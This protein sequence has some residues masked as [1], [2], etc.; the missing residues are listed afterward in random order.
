[1]ATDFD[2]GFDD[3]YDEEERPV[4]GAG[5]TP[6]E[7]LPPPPEIGGMGSY[8]DIH[9]VSASTIG[10]RTVS[11]RL[12]T[13]AAGHPTVTQL[14]V[15]KI[16]NGRP[17]GL[18]AIDAEASEDDLVRMFV[19]SMPKA[20]EG[21][22]VFKLRPIDVDGNEMGTEATTIIGE[23]HRVLEQMKRSASAAAMG[24][25]PM[26][27]SN[28]GLPSEVL[29][30]MTRSIDQTRA[31][32]DGERER[33]REL[34][35]QMAQERIDLASSAA[36]SIQAMSERLLETERQSRESALRT[37][38]DRNQQ[39]SDSM[40]AF[41]Q[42][43][44]EMMRAETQRQAEREERE[45]ETDRE[46]WDR[47]REEVEVRR[48]RE[49]DEEDRRRQRDR[50]EW[51]RKMLEMKAEAAE[52]ERLRERAAE[53]R[54]AEEAER[55]RAEQERWERQRRIEK[56]ET[57]RK[58][59]DRKREHE[60][61]MKMLDI[62][63][64]Q[65][66][67]HDKQMAQIQ[68][69]QIAA[70]I[71]AQKPAQGIKDMIKEGASTLKMLGV[72]PN[73]LVQRF[74]NPPSSGGED[75]NQW[76]DLA[77]K[78][79]TSIGEVAKAKVQADAAQARRPEPAFVA[80]TLMPQVPMVQQQP[81]QQ[82]PGQPPI[83]PPQQPGQAQPQPQPPQAPEAPQRPRALPGSEALPLKAQNLARRA[84][85]GL[86]RQVVS[87]DRDKW[88]ALIAASITSEPAIYHYVNAVT[89]RAA[90]TEARANPALVEALVEALKGSPLVPEDLNYGAGA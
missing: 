51:E 70:Q 85:R 59:A 80:P 61:R 43:Q 62:E 23:H 17:I 4:S 66:R 6:V 81:Q 11:P 73:E 72:E 76:A 30:L 32:L 53:R 34:M 36:S 38:A 82:Q 22:S 54:R 64:E 24:A 49:R 7:H 31:S 52:K 65:R 37:E 46:R 57:D 79:L 71:N 50:D 21:S 26:M 19:S 88:D 16:E 5:Q 63:A 69:A 90:L 15:W 41:F 35:H 75:S 20:G 2:L 74:L 39:T 33:S 78:T 13:A 29:S 86:V 68:Q 56:E 14:R 60:M 83:Q 3:D 87:A 67:E 44:L 77:G 58:E 45:R 89:V 10:G 42:S 12:F 27:S 84:L 47:E 8:S 9:G 18:G 25:A 48:Q 55:R 28:A 40:A 1:M